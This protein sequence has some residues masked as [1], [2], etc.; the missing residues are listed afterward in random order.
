MAGLIQQAQAPQA[1]QQPGKADPAAVDRIVI[2]AKQVLTQIAPQLIQM[3]KGAGDPVRGLAQTLIFVM[4]QLY[5]KSQGSMPAEAIVPAAQQIIDD[6]AKIGEAGG[7]FKSSPDL[8][9]KAMAVAAQ[10]FMRQNKM[11]PNA[12]MGQ[13]KG[14]AQPQAPAPAAQPLAPPVGG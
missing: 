8:L 2:A 1:S 7:L 5:Q 6:I 13:A 10:L 14:G 4:M 3:M 9:K 12:I 11:D